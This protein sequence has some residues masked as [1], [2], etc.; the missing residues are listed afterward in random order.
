MTIAGQ[1]DHA[2]TPVDGRRL[3]GR[4]DDRDPSPGE[5]AEQ[6]HDLRRGRRVQTRG[7]FVQEE[8]ARLGE[9]LDRDAG[10]L[11]LAARQHPDRDVAPVGQVQVAHRLVDHA[12]GLVGRG[13]RRQPKSR[14]VLERA[15]QRHLDVDDVVLR[16]VADA[17]AGAAPASTR[18]PSWVTRPADGARNPAR[19]SSRVVF[20]APLPPTTATSS[21]GSMES[22][23]SWRIWR[24]PACW[25]TPTASMR[26]L[27]ALVVSAG[28]VGLDA[29]AASAGPNVSSIMKSSV[30]SGRFRSPITVIIRTS[31]Q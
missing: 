3:V 23:T 13:A 2:V 28:A 29:A 12:V 6:A 27:T 21:P 4:E 8:G 15:P 31:G 24:R 20:P 1:E 5:S 19:I 22:D 7:G 9:Q 30:R 17:R 25:P 10:P 16:D 26:P 18:T 14:R 11:A